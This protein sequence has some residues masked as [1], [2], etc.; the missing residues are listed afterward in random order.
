MER[1]GPQPDPQPR[2]SPLATR[3][4]LP[5]GDAKGA[6]GSHLASLKGGIGTQRLGAGK[7]EEKHLPQ[8]VPGKV[9]P[10]QQFP[11]QHSVCTL[12]ITAVCVS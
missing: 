7:P 6:I 5:W 2:N 11:W 12:L 4:S 8:A 1:V 9:S 3:S 10:G